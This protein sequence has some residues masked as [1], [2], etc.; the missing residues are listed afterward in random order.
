[1][2]T[3]LFQQENAPARVLRQIAID[4]RAHLGEPL[5][6]HNPASFIFLAS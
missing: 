2:V 6:R 3:Y 5:D 1:M 4:I